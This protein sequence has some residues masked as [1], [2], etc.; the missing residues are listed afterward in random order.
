MCTLKPA[1]CNSLL[2]FQVLQAIKDS[3]LQETAG[4][5]L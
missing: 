5:P 2:D 4:C 1:N 3:G